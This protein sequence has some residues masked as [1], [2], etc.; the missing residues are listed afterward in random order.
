M[1]RGHPAVERAARHLSQAPEPV[2]RRRGAH[3]TRARHDGHVS[4]TRPR[5]GA[6]RPPR[7]HDATT[8]RRDTTAT[9]P[10]HGRDTA[11]D[12]DGRG[13]ARLRFPHAHHRNHPVRHDRRRR[14]P[15]ADP[16]QHRINWPLA[17]VTGIIG[18]F[19]GGLFVSFLAGD[20]LDLKPSGIFGSIFGAVAGDPA[21]GLDPASPRPQEG[22]APAPARRSLTD[23]PRP[24]RDACRRLTAGMPAGARRRPRLGAC[25]PPTRPPVARSRPDGPR[26]RRHRLRRQPADPAAPARGPHGAGRRHRP[27]QGSR[28]LVGRPGR[29]G[30]DGRARRRHRRRRGR[31]RRRRRST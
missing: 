14:R 26:H 27:R 29:A 25:Q 6:T 21:L 30:A 23:R 19:V 3:T 13:G 2:R 24:R 17:F 4:T 16:A 31:G 7:V 15:A 8:T 18:S 12:P 5:H 10:R 22:R 9:C 11:R 1:Y 28:P 20:G